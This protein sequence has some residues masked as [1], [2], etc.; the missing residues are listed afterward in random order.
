MQ[1]IAS[2]SRRACSSSRS[3]SSARANKAMHTALAHLDKLS[4][5]L[6]RE[7]EGQCI[8]YE[9]NPGRRFRSENAR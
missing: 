9:T 2:F 5:V 8:A 7:A 6:E 1:I 4:D 3:L